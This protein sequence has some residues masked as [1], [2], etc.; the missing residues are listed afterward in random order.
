LDVFIDEV[1]VV[2]AL[3]E[4]SE[5]CEGGEVDVAESFDE[6]GMT[7]EVRGMPRILGQV[8]ERNGEREWGGEDGVEGVELTIGEGFS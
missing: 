1:V 2:K 6:D 3:L 7:C 8:T 4:S 5:G